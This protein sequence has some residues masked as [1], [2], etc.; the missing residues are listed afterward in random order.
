[1]M[2]LDTV[3]WSLTHPYCFIVL[4]IASI[5]QDESQQDQHSTTHNNNG[6]STNNGRQIM[7]TKTAKCT[8]KMQSYK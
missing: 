7:P 2:H 5:L 6:D 8:A 4:D 3:S 1:M